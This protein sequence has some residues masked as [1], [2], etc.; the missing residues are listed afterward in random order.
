MGSHRIAPHVD[1]VFGPKAAPVYDAAT[2]KTLDLF[3]AELDKVLDRMMPPDVQASVSPHPGTDDLVSLALDTIHGTSDPLAAQVIAVL[4][5][6]LLDARSELGT[7]KMMLSQALT[8]AHQRHT[9]SLRLRQRPTDLRAT[10][11]AAA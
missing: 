5:E 1:E 2:Q 10:D 3:N 11:Q 8:L 4:A 9:E 7:R 6:A